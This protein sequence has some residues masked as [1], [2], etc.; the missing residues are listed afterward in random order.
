MANSVFTEDELKVAKKDVLIE[1]KAATK[2][3]DV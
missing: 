1:I 2:L 3:V